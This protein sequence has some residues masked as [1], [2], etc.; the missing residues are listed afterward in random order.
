VAVAIV[1]VAVGGTA[2]AAEA[3]GEGRRRGVAVDP[4]SIE[5][6]RPLHQGERYELPALG[7]RNPGTVVADYAF[8]V[9]ATG[10][11]RLTP[12]ARWFE[13]GPTALRLEPGVRGATRPRIGLPEAA[14]PGE[15]D[16]LLVARL[17][18]SGEGA[19][20]GAAAAARLSFTVQAAQEA[21]PGSRP[22]ALWSVVALLA[23]LGSLVVLA[24]R[25]TVRVE[26]RVLRRRSGDPVR[27][28]DDA[29]LSG[30]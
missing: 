29:G 16:A 13:L 25:V 10:S 26:R 14:E 15:Y 24:G 3:A 23:V 18:P 30:S 5:V 9:E 7:V 28:A 22:T 2:S 21:G 12:P 27:A 19:G 8:A 11:D 20:V 1:L 6:V 17:V 4:G